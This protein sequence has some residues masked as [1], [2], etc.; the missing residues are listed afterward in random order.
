MRQNLGL[1]YPE[2]G[3]LMYVDVSSQQITIPRKKKS[4]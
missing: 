4:Q 3:L 1:H 2:T